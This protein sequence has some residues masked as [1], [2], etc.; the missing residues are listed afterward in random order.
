V[1]N[2]PVSGFD[3]LGLAGGEATAPGVGLPPFGTSCRCRVYTTQTASGCIVTTVYTDCDDGSGPRYDTTID[4]PNAPGGGPDQGGP[5]SGGQP[6]SQGN[7]PSQ[8][9]P[10]GSAPAGTSA[11]KKSPCAKAASPHGRGLDLSD[12]LL[13]GAPAPLK[14]NP[15]QIEWDRDAFPFLKFWERGMDADDHYFC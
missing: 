9:S 3:V 11:P 5:L 6:P 12:G 13:G 8:T 14:K 4:C 2:N 15:R 7:G 10:S 1:A